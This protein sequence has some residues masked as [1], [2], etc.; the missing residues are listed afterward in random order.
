MSL[1]LRNIQEET[2]LNVPHIQ[3]LSGYLQEAFPKPALS[4]LS[5]RFHSVQQVRQSTDCLN[6]VLNKEFLPVFT[7]AFSKAISTLKF[8]NGLCVYYIL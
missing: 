7:I 4:T 3:L 6:K 2:L 5:H 8:I 1:L